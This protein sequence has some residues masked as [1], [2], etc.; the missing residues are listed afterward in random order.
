M[1]LDEEFM[2]MALEE[3][4]IA[5][6]KGEVPVGAVLVI[7]NKVIAKAHNLVESLMDATAHAEI[8]CIKKASQ[9]LQNW[10][11]LNSTL[12]T[13]LEPCCMCAGAMILSRVGTLVWG[14]PDIRQGAH[15]SFVNILSQKH[16]IH[17][18]SVRSGVLAE[19]SAELMKK[20]FRQRRK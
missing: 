3:A 19:E 16:P 5:S 20:F 14:A 2:R 9:V 4:E 6:S 15:G 11:L 7:E 8:L 17:N 10:R 12:Y 1:F 13:T 18:I